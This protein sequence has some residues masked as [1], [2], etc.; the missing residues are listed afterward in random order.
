MRDALEHADADQVRRRADGR[1][2]P[3]D[4]CAERGE[5]HQAERE[6]P[7]R[8]PR[9]FVTRRHP[10]QVIH[11]RQP[12]RKHHRGGRGVADPHRE[13]GGHG[14]IDHEHADGARSHERR[15]QRREGDAAVDAVHEHRLG[16]DEAAD[17]QK[18]D[19]IGKRR[20]RAACVSDPEDNGEHRAEH[21]RD[22]HR[23]RLGHPEH[24][25]KGHDRGH[26]MA[27][28]GEGHRQRQQHEQHRRR[29]PEPNGAAPAI[30]SL[31]RRRVA[32]RPRRSP[33]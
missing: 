20:E 6:L 19:G 15:R 5:Q 21:R 2:H 30:E 33:G 9:G 24:D 1:R 8:L 7:H 11:D 31:L 18:D 13:R 12:D 26:P 28:N 3:S 14:G 22:G 10:H 17:E 23:Q 29:E 27:R 16:Q 32:S 25:H 4:R